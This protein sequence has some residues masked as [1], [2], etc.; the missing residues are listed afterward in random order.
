MI[1]EEIARSFKP[2]TV[3][4]GHYGSG[5]TNFTMNVALDCASTGRRVTVIDMDIVNPYFRVSELRRELEAAGVEL[6][7]PVFSEAGTSL[8]VP[9]LTGRI[10]PSIESASSDHLVLI[11]VGG[12]D[13]GS[14][15]LGRYA[16][17]IE[18]QDHAVLYIANRFRNLVQDMDD[19]LENMREIEAASR[20]RLTGI[21]NN[22][23]L[24]DATD[25]E[26]VR[27]GSEYAAELSRLS[28]LPVICTTVPRELSSVAILKLYPVQRYVKAP[29][30]QSAQ[31]VV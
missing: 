15:A 7:A 30:E 9:S 6:V 13:A 5:K 23:H 28:A 12:D 17:A 2:V 14:I 25:E 20:L 27:Q 19:A 10:M 8:D 22:S 1:P 31:A 26:A 4:V 3:I 11:D 29:W 18:A 16:R 24:Q 21:V